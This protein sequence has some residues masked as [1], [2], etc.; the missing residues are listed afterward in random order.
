MSKQLSILLYT[1]AILSLIKTTTAAPRPPSTK[2]HSDNR[3]DLSRHLG[4]KSPYPFRGLEGGRSSGNQGLPDHCEII[5]VQMVGR[6]GT[7][8]PGKGNIKS[9]K[10]FSKFLKKHKAGVPE[11]FGWMVDWTNPYHERDAN[12]LVPGGEDDLHWLGKR[13]ARRYES[14]FKNATYSPKEFTFRSS[15]TSRSGQS[16]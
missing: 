10:K 7:R 6:H 4:S 11:D 5:Q 13:V 16:G 15:M 14:L 1:L 9:I 8:R 2:T 3:F 12:L